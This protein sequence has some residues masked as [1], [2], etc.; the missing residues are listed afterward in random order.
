MLILD[1]PEF[2]AQYSVAAAEPIS[3]SDR[4]RPLGA[5][6]PAYVIYTSGSTGR[7]KGVVVTH[8]GLGGLMATQQATCALSA[9]SRVLHVASPSFDQSLF[10]LLLTI[11]AS[12]TMVIAQRRCTAPARN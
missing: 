10:E 3:Y 7:P 1:S 2:V 8:N 4:V 6:H 9:E 12:S 5:D 11:G